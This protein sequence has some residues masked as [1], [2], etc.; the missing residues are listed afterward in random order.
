MSEADELLAAHEA[1]FDALA[2]RD[3]AALN[4]LLAEG[5]TYRHASGRFQDK[6]AVMHDALER[7]RR[8]V[9]DGLEVRRFGDTGVVT[10][11]QPADPQLANSV[12]VQLLLVWARLDGRWQL[13]ARQATAPRTMS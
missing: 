4:A 5:L 13:I 6:A 2:N 3:E 12:A 10:G 11:V 8:P 7:G 1:W 9:I